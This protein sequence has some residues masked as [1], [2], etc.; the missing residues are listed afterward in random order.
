MVESVMDVFVR[1]G[2]VPEDTKILAMELSTVEQSSMSAL[3]QSF[4]RY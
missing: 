2:T 1:A 3:V 4:T